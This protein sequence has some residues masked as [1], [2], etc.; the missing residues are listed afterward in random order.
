MI[1]G[2]YTSAAG[3]L[4]LAYRQD[5]I[6]NNLANSNTPGY[7]K[8][9]VFIHDLITADLYLN[10]HK[11]ASS[12]ETPRKI[13]VL[14][15]AYRASVGNSS[16]VVVQDTDF[17]Q[18]PLDITGNDFNLAI[19][20]DGFFT[21]QTPQGI[22]YTRSGYF[23]VGPDGS[24]VTQDGHKV[25]GRGGPINVQGNNL[26]VLR[27]GDVY[28]DNELRGRLRITDFPKPY[29]MTKIK[30]NLFTPEAGG[31]GR[32]S[33]NFTLKQGALE[34]TNAHPVSQLVQMI[35]IQRMF[36]V[37]QR[38]I[39]LQDETLQQAITQAGRV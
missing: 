26:A 25:L 32:D 17:S 21:I 12:G 3:M 19:E 33:D 36:E 6:T 2:L 13:N 31:G 39:R 27:E 7:K 35:E 9:R 22:R 10:E 14:P 30:D 34:K 28:V 5:M 38:V 18:G 24:L 20:G 15:P 16:R 11:T 29:K 8:D 37:G 23:S 1:K 4:P